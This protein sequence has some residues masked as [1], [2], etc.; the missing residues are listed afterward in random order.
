MEHGFDA[1]TIADV[2]KRADVA[3]QTVF[4]HFATKEELFFDGRTPWVDGPADAVRDRAPAVPPLVALRAYLIDEIGRLVASL[5][6]AE[7][8]AYIA[9]LTGS[10]TLLARERELFH[11]AERR[12]S[13]A[14]LEAWTAPDVEDSPH[15][16]V[17]AAPVTAAVWLSTARVMLVEQRCRTTVEGATDA[18]AGSTH[19]FA[20]RLLGQMELCLGMISG[21]PSDLPDPDTGWP[22]PAAL[23][24]G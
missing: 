16:P 10:V 24:A 12:L 14:L 19:A 6:T 8:R 9:T 20:E 5:V 1:V 21:L 17:T 13:A 11:E 4:N 22:Q 15:D 2:A 3:V 18:G 23:Q 7:R